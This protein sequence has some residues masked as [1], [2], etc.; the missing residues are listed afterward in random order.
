MLREL[1]RNAASFAV[2]KSHSQVAKT[3]DLLKD[4]KGVLRSKKEFVELS[5]KLDSKYNKRYL[6][7]EYDHA[8]TTARAARKWDDIQRTKRLYP[9]LIYKA[10]NDD[11]T[12]QLHRKW[13]G[14]TLPVEH[15][16]WKS[17]Y[18]PNDWGCRCTV[19]RTQKPID[20]KGYDVEDMP[21]LPKQFNTNTG[22]TGRIF[23]E[24]HPYFS[25]GAGDAKAVAQRL[26]QHKLEY[27]DY[28][29]LKDAKVSVSPWADTAD[30]INNL[31]IGSGLAKA[32]KWDVKIRPDVQNIKTGIGRKGYSNP[33]F[34]IDGMYGDV[35]SVL[36]LKRLDA[37]GEALKQGAEVLILEIKSK[38][39][40]ER[41]MAMISG[42]IKVRGGNAFKRIVVVKDGKYYQYE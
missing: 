29:Y 23:D 28:T 20:A 37:Y 30:Y 11:R 17:H 40:V 35:K 33:E 36:S 31:R 18:P 41:I 6:G 26:K 27:P 4:D 21:K 13:D 32:F 10:I 2:F 14:I 8:V 9:N 25:D 7:T 15:P 5:R 1:K 19:T 16:F 42:Q 38:Q 12:R 3:V 22:Q 39:T 34:L 24:S